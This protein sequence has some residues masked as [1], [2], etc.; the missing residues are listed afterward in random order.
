MSEENV[1]IVREV[2]AAAAGRD[3]ESALA[4]YDPLIE[5]MSPIPRWLA[6]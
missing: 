4:A 6:W 1:E 5:W 2:Y 3:A